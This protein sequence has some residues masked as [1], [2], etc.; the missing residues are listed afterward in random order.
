MTS[1][2]EFLK[3]KSEEQQ[4]ESKRRRREEWVAA[5]E[6]LCDQIV[7]WLREDD[8]EQILE[9]ATFKDTKTEEGLGTYDTAA[10]R[11]Q[12]GEMRVFVSVVARNAVGAVGRH[13]EIAPRAEGVVEISGEGRRYRIFRVDRGGQD[14]WY[15]IDKEFAAIPFD[16]D[17]LEKILLDAFS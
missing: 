15:Y 6:R 1:F 8:T 2:Q 13:G 5:V 9:I 16:K 10:L 14:A 12:L 17:C 7:T 4:D 3:K 11:V